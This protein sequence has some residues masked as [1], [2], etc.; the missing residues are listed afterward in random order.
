MHG[1][2]IHR[3]LK[4][5]R[6]GAPF[7]TIEDICAEDLID[8]YTAIVQSSMRVWEGDEIWKH[9]RMKSDPRDVANN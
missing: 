3:A 8:A 5:G 4:K 9:I 7:P 2:E 6:E 1:Q